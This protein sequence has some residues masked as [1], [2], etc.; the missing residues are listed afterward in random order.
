MKKKDFILCCI[1]IF[2][3]LLFFIISGVGLPITIMGMIS[4]ILII[5]ACS[6]RVERREQLAKEIVE[7]V[8]KKLDEQV[9]EKTTDEP[10]KRQQEKD[11]NPK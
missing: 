6:K 3:F 2:A 5:W 1:L 4:L 7:E 10:K 9:I 8:T 11:N